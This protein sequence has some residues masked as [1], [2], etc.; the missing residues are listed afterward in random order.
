MSASTRQQTIFFP[1]RLIS[2]L[3][4][5]LFG[6]GYALILSSTATS[7]LG[8]VYWILAARTYSPSIV[9]L[10]SAAISAMMFLA[11]VA[12]LNLTSALIRF[13]PGA[14]Q[15]TWRLVVYA[16][17]ISIGVA[18]LVSL[19]F[20]LWLNTWAPALSS[21]TANPVFNPWF[22]GATMAWC[23]FVLQD[24]VLTGLHQAIWVPLENTIFSI[25]KI[26][27]LLMF[28][29]PLARYGIFASWT[30]ALIVALLPTNFLIFRRLIPKRA[31]AVAGPVAPIALAQGIKYVAAD[32]LGSLFWLVSTALLPVIV[33]RQAGATA[34]AYFYLAWTMAY[35]L[36]LVSP[37]M[38]SS[39]IVEAATDQARLS[40][41]SYRVFVH[42][43]RLLVPVVAIVMVGAPY[44]LRIFGSGYAAEGTTL[45]RLLA[46]SAIPNIIN[47]LYISI[48]RVQR[49]LTALVMVLAGLCMLVLTLSY[50][51]L[52][53][54]GITGVG[55]AWLVSQTLVAAI[56]WPTRLRPLWSSH[57][58]TEQPTIGLPPG[59]EV[60]PKE[61]HQIEESK[62]AFGFRRYHKGIV[63]AVGG[64]TIRLA[65]RVAIELRLASLLH[66]WWDDHSCRRHVTEHARL[67]PLI[68][69][70]IPPQPDMP[71]PAT[72]TAQRVVRTVSDMTVILV[73]PPGQAAT[74]VLKLPRTNAAVASLHWQKT[75][76]AT[77]HADP[78]LGEW[79]ALLPTLLTQGEVD[80]QAYGVERMLP[81]L[82]AQQ[83]L[84]HPADDLRIQIA[85]AAAIGEFHR[86]TAT[87]AAVNAEM[88]DRWIDEPLRLIERV[89]TRFSDTTYNRKAMRRLAE[90][91]YQ[92]LAGR[93]LCLS[94]VHGDF[95]PGN[96]LVTP[97]GGQL[98][99]IA[100]WELARPDDLPLLDVLQLLLSTRLLKQRREMG[101]IVRTL[102]S[103]PE[104][105][106]H[107]QALLDVAQ[108]VQ[109]GDP[110]NWR[111]M[112]LLC[113][114]RHV[115]ANLTKSNRYA[116]NWWWVTRNI[117][118]VL[119]S[120]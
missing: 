28:A 19:I 103:R 89:N 66:G 106:S 51:L 118:T 101:D 90:E 14:G 60:I 98:L 85:A 45:L 29:R 17:L 11:G 104:W 31:Q 73:G 54:Y 117:E 94:W 67:I 77:L 30:L 20:L 80:G 37:N 102:L 119:Q 55:L 99:G 65:Q 33:T 78:R 35:S 71:P 3:R 97:G 1:T 38:G 47:A 96:I 48:A 69:T 23:I 6:N 107:E 100:D 46:L 9:G 95:V 84:V 93:T 74:G 79:S 36:Y 113:W 26:V 53:I 112:L 21:L 12:Q 13:I 83:M 86:R 87:L 7:V 59:F 49:R 27:L 75:V 2:H 70:T 110:I 62:D 24:S 40:S 92:A 42:T 32:Y 25:V 50:T 81:G 8:V 56:L 91:L 68:L 116:S 64:H 82:V 18:G 115:A 111:T 34:N 114:L 58:D 44:L 52:P 105:L 72:W 43:I 4:T 10:N 108:T 41:Y 63:S 120:L 109:P 5:P 16:Y 61:H 22:I 15:L 39:L 88:L 76:L 57:H